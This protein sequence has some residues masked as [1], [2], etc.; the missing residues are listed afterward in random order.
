MESLP[1]LTESSERGWPCTENDWLSLM[2]PAKRTLESFWYNLAS[3]AVTV[4]GLELVGNICMSWS[5]L[6]GLSGSWTVDVAVLTSL[7]GMDAIHVT[8]DCTDWNVLLL[9]IQYS[10]FRQHI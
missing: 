2:E 9:C 10:V 4:V 5:G 6:S 7:N 8:H 1:S 3:A